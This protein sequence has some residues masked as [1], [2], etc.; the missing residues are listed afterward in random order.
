MAD[1]PRRERWLTFLLLPAIV[2]AVLVLVWVM[3]R[4]SFQLEKLRE[5]SVIEA[6]LLLA[7]EKADRLDKRIIEQDNVIR[8]TLAVDEREDFGARWREAAQLQTPTVRAVLVLDLSAPDK[9]VVAMASRAP[10]PESERFRRLLV[11]AMLPDLKLERPPLEELRHLHK[12]YRGQNYLLSHWET[13]SAGRRYLTVV[14]HDVS[15]IVHD[16]FPEL[17]ADA[18]QSRVN[19]VDAE[20]RIVFGPAQSRGGLTLGRQF[21]TTLY[22]WTLNVTMNSA[23]ELATAVARRRLLEMAL[24]GLSGVVVI[25]G[26]IVIVV[27]AERERKLS[28]LKGDFVANVSHELKTP[29]S[30]VRMFGELLQSGRVDSE[31]KRKQYLQI[32]VSE[33]ERLGSLIENVLDFAKVERGK[34]AYEFVEANLTDVVTRAVEACRPR[35]EREQVEIETEFPDGPQLAW[36]DER[37]IEIAVINLVDNAL[38]YA[39]GGKRVQVAVRRRRDHLEIRVSDQGPGIAPEDRKRIFERFVRGQSAH[40]KQVRGSGIG[41]A[42]VKHIAQ[43]HGGACD[44][45]DGTPVGAT[46]VF[47]LSMAPRARHRLLPFSS[48][49]TS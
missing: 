10:G 46:F 4:S 3:F 14:W 12:T 31:D 11:H 5:Q 33:S 44:I 39:P 15:R 20:G 27:A 28:N 18:Q 35:A 9:P 24:V 6:T 2:V 26:I 37:A 30:L 45:E 48:R 23:E 34:A 29:L 16:V 25:L 41:L 42:L 13:E 19:V 40:G 49:A 1:R 32:I 21:E 38:K 43:A 47:T 8:S 22:K 7:N 17:Y 36:I